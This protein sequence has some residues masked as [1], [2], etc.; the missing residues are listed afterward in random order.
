MNEIKPI[1]PI[2]E[3]HMNKESSKKD[4]IK[5]QKLINNK[6]SFANI[7]ESLQTKNEENKEF[8]VNQRSTINLKPRINFDMEIIEDKTKELL[9]KK[10]YRN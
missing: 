5:K 8:V 10:A 9:A 2:I 6:T 7:L 1:N 4:D 3:I